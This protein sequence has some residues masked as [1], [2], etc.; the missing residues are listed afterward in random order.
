MLPHTFE[1]LNRAADSFSNLTKAQAFWL[2][3]ARL[4][5]IEE[6]SGV[7]FPAIPDNMKHNWEDDCFFSHDVSRSN[8]RSQSCGEGSPQGVL[9]NSTKAE[10]IAAC[11]DHLNW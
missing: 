6:T 8:L 2:F 4:D 7:R 9:P 11:I 3:V 10:R 5:L 1:N